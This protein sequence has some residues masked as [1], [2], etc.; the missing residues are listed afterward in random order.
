MFSQ[1]THGRRPKSLLAEELGRLFDDDLLLGTVLFAL[2]LR[3]GC[4]KILTLVS[5]KRFLGIIFKILP[6]T[7]QRT[8]VSLSSTQTADYDNCIPDRLE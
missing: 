6:N 3:H 2:D 4:I 7:R 1:V 5:Q 8:V